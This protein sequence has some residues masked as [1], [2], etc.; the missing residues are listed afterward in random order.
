MQKVASPISAQIGRFLTIFKGATESV[1]G[2]SCSGK[3]TSGRQTTWN[4]R[5]EGHHTL[6]VWLREWNT[7][8]SDVVLGRP[9]N[10]PPMPEAL[11]TL[12][13]KRRAGIEQRQKTFMSVYLVQ[14]SEQGWPKLQKKLTLDDFHLTVGSELIEAAHS[15]GIMGIASKEELLGETGRS[16]NEL[17]GTFGSGAEAAPVALYVISR[18]VPTLRAVNWL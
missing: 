4:L 14:P 11:S 10:V 7:G 17:C 16:R 8:E 3:R 13:N 9:S 1:Q 12:L 15:L 6:P 18:V 5:V 2:E